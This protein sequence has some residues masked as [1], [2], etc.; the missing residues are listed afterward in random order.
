MGGFG[1][2]LVGGWLGGWID[3]WVGGWVDGWVS[4]VCMSKTYITIHIYIKMCMRVRKYVC[5]YSSAFLH[6]Y[7]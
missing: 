5:P 6:V 3:G 1:I 2:K 4:C 7:I